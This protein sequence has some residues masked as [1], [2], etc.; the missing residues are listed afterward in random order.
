MALHRSET[1]PTMRY[2][3]HLTTSDRTARK[4]PIP[5]KDTHN[6]LDSIEIVQDK[7]SIVTAFGSFGTGNLQY[8]YTHTR[9]TRQ[10][11]NS[12]VIFVLNYHSST[13]VDLPPMLTYAPKPRK[14]KRRATCL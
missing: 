9:T 6:W 3:L 2:I 14:G 5:R 13:G 8:I 7:A 12:H 4:T 10:Y 11:S 1:I